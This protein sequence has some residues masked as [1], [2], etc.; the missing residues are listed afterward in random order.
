MTL[1]IDRRTAM[2]AAASAVAV[3]T[4]GIGAMSAA[5]AMTP[6]TRPSASSPEGRNALQL[7][8]EGV[9]VMR[10]RSRADFFDPTG[11]TYQALIHGVL[12]RSS[13]TAF[14]DRVFAGAPADHPVRVLAEASWSTCP[15]GRIQFLPWHRIYVYFFE[16]VLRAACGDPGF[17]LPYWDYTRGGEHAQIPPALIEAVDGSPLNNALFNS[18]RDA[19]INGLFGTAARL[20]DSDISLDALRQPGFER[21]ETAEGLSLALEQVPH[22]VVHTDV[23]G[24]DDI[25]FPVGDMSSVTT[26]GRDPVFWLHHSNIDR[27][28]ESWLRAGNE[29]T[30]T[31]KDETWYSEKW[32][33]FD[34][35][36]ARQDW[37]LADFNEATKDEPVGYDRFEAVPRAEAFVPPLIASNTFTVESEANIALTPAGNEVELR[38]NSVTAQ[39]PPSAQ[40][41]ESA[42]VVIDELQAAAEVAVNFDVYLNLPASGLADDARRVGSISFFGLVMD[43]MGHKQRL[44]FDVTEHVRQRIADGQ[45]PAKPTVTI[46]PRGNFAGRRATVGQV[47]LIIE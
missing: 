34:E 9:R 16:R 42:R 20:P 26:A 44:I 13:K 8:R 37:S 28:W 11:W 43:G 31:Y 2:L 39:A 15:H 1:K 7:Y 33:F 3:T 18:A 4:T 38:S 24:S 21:T 47:R 22:G 14:I 5:K 10:E 46:L 27:L 41:I 23:G 40:A 30:E 6:H 35:T 29:T 32:T 45:W 19:R 25:G 36:G 17:V 12:D